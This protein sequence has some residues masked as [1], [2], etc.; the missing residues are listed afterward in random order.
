MFILNYMAHSIEINVKE[1]M[2]NLLSGNEVTGKTEL[3]KYGVMVLK[4]L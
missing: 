3:Q 4:K 2:I 1:P